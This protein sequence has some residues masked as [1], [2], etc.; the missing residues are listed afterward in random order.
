MEKIVNLI[1]EMRPLSISTSD[2][3][4]QVKFHRNFGTYLLLDNVFK[5]N[6]QVSS[7]NECQ[8]WNVKAGD[9]LLYTINQIGNKTKNDKL[10]FPAKDSDIDFEQF[11]DN[12]TLIEKLVDILKILEYQ[13]SYEYYNK[14]C[15]ECN[16][17]LGFNCVGSGKS[18]LS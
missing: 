13:M 16:F 1:S 10:I 12:R 6:F 15:E 18:I 14:F 4:S 17:D 11:A 7:D 5:S 3:T 8:V 9:K 2:N